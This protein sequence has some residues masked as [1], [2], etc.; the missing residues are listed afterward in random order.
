MLQI[1]GN[2]FTHEWLQFNN[3]YQD[4]WDL[5]NLPCNKGFSDHAMKHILINNIIN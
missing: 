1:F 3:L 2:N 4:S 5:L